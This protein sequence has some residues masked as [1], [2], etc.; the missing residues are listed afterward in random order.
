M[1]TVAPLTSTVPGPPTSAVTVW[2]P[3]AKSRVAPV[4]T[5]MGMLWVPSVVSCK[6]VPPVMISWLG[7]LGG[8]GGVGGGAQLAGSDW[9]GS[10]TGGG[11][12]LVVLVVVVVVV[13]VVVVELVGSAPP[14]EASESTGSRLVGVGELSDVVVVVDGSALATSCGCSLACSLGSSFA[15]SLD[16]SLDFSLDSCL[17]FSFVSCFGA[18]ASAKAVACA[19]CFSL[20]FF[21]VSSGVPLC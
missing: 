14:E 12:A 18:M 19:C 10:I 15:F 1:S 21:L 2:V 17:A 11:G 4:S 9:H 13:E 7:L 20:T 5:V 6:V 3:P 16:S 8:G